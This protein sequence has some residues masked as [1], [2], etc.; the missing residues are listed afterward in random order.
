MT[1][2]VTTDGRPIVGAYGDVYSAPVGTP[3]PADMTEYD[4]PP[5]PWVKLGLISEDGATWTPPSEE[6]TDIKAWQSPYPI[7]IVT[8]SLTT[9]V[10]FGLMEWD[11]DTIPFAL[12][13]GE[14]VD[15]T[16]LDLVTY[17]PP[18]PGESESKALLLKVLD[19]PIKLALYYPKGRIS[20]REDTTFKP[21]EAALLS[22]TFGIEG[23]I[24]IDS[25]FELIFPADE[26]GPGG[27]APLATGA[28]PGQPGAWTP[29]GSIPPA[30][31]IA[32]DAANPPLVGS[33][34]WALDDY[35]LCANSDSVYWDGTGWTQGTHP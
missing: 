20:E 23:D 18:G 31:F 5:A 12:G 2:P 28:T 7:R 30:S 4:T 13:G 29:S 26:I 11:R 16:A 34:T 17:K 24:N 8:T 35:V 19:S 1:T 22:V 6:T 10:S 33:G 27:G 9:S 21:D 14:F 3:P 15:N 25:P 32:L